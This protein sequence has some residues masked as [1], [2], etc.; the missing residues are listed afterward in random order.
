MKSML[1]SRLFRQQFL[2]LAL[3][4]IFFFAF[5]VAG[6]YFRTQS[7]IETREM[8][9]AGFY[10]DAVLLSIQDWLAERESDI[11]WLASILESDAERA[12]TPLAPEAHAR[13]RTLLETKSAFS[14]LILLDTEGRVLFGRS[15]PS[16]RSIGLADRDY[17]RAARDG[18]SF[19][20]EAFRNRLTGRYAFA[21]SRPLRYRGEIR[22]VLAG[23]V[24]LSDLIQIV[25]HMGLGS[26][27]TIY[28]T[29]V[30]RNLVADSAAEASQPAP[31]AAE[32]GP[33]FDTFAAHQAAARRTGAGKY[34]GRSGQTVVGAYGWVER[35]NLGLVVELQSDRA[36]LPIT[37]L[38]EFFAE[39]AAGLVVIQLLLAYALS[40]RLV[41]P[42][43]ALAAAA[44]TPEGQE[45]PQV[46][47]PRTNTELDSLVEAFNRMAKSIR[48]REGWLKESAA[49]DSLTG[50]Y[51]HAKIEEFL[52]FEMRRHKRDKRPLCFVMMDI[53][54]FKSVNDTFGHQAGDTVLR[55]T[56]HLLLRSGREGDIVGRY[57]G[58]E[59]SVILDAQTPEDAAAYC[60]RIRKA[61]EETAYV[62][63]GTDIRVTMSLGY[64]CAL[65]STLGTFE[66]IRAADKA[67]YAAKQ[68]GRNRVVA[69]PL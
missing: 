26:L 31:D 36:L 64:A 53:D 28:M 2:V 48:E 46:R 62:H 43:R 15:G 29:D 65:A 52:E 51:N 33:A 18:R 32:E 11:A 69:A 54:H 47:V 35:L 42:I 39:F 17:F 30:D 8:E 23:T 34:E 4:T 68:A 1:Q 22:A 6:I 67:L 40:A 60:E 59:F 21:V 24:L 20:S 50:L 61:V 27:G 5:M 9:I 12:G 58:E 49:R 38:L 14:D 37:R 13:F 57:G 45:Y 19:V 55:E 10:R 25:E 66:L 16:T 56:A 3:L 41:R 63:E 7:S 44:D